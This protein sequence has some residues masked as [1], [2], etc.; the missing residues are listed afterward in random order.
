MARSHHVGRSRPHDWTVAESAE[1]AIIRQTAAEFGILNFHSEYSS[2]R[3][4]Q[5]EGE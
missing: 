2:Q 5:D 1:V 4:Y 3:Q